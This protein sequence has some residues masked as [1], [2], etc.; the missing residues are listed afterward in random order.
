MISHSIQKLISKQ[1]LVM[2]SGI[3]HVELVW[4]PC[5]NDVAFTPFAG[6]QTFH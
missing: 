2:Y 3:I 6:I 4:H 1:H 5:D